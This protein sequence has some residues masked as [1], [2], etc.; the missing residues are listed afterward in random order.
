MKI[1]TKAD[2]SKMFDGA[3]L[4]AFISGGLGRLRQV[5]GAYS[6]PPDSGKKTALA[7]LLSRLL[8]RGTAVILYVSGWGVWASS[9][10]LDLYY[11]YRRSLGDARLLSEAPVHVFEA[12]E[13]DAFVSIFSMAF[14]FVWDAWAFD[15][16]A[17]AL[18]RIS[19]DEWLEAFTAGNQPNEEFGAEL[20]EFGMRPLAR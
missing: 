4:D 2:A 20:E 9:E 10:N 7:R 3:A 8:F 6:I 5:R 12:P 17:Q 19:H 1:L 13:A 18:V 16:H 15:I 14:Y 11:G